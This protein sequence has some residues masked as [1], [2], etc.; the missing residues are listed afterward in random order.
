[1]LVGCCVKCKYLDLVEAGNEGTCPQCGGK[2]ISLGVDAN[3]WNSL[4]NDEMLSLIESAINKA[5]TP[6]KP[7]IVQPVFKKDSIQ[8]TPVIKNESSD[9][10]DNYDEED[11]I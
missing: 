8:N 5:K 2:V 6:I 1:M 11:I 10:A 7:A 4:G 3:K 9:Y